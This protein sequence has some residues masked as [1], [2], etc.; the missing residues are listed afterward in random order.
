MDTWISI[1]FFQFHQKLKKYFSVI[2]KFYILF[3]FYDVVSESLWTVIAVTASVK[4]ER[5]GQ[6]HTSESLLHLSAM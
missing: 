1:Q 3:A 6:G 4:D 5:G 2:R